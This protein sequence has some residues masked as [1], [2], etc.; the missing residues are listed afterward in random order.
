M[1]FHSFSQSGLATS[2]FS[3]NLPYSAVQLYNAEAFLNACT[4]V[5]Y[6]CKRLPTVDAIEVKAT[7]SVD[8]V[9]YIIKDNVELLKSEIMRQAII[10]QSLG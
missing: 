3:C 7:V 6:G 8:N 1:G 2:L 9:N 5:F 10:T 4:K